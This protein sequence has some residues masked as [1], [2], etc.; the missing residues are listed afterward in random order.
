MMLRVVPVLVI[1][2]VMCKKEIM[3]SD[4]YEWFSDT[5]YW[6]KSRSQMWNE[7]VLRKTGEDVAHV[8]DQ[9]QKPSWT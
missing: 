1:Q 9:S 4:P 7:K 6:A 8:V 2:S 5:S 3:G